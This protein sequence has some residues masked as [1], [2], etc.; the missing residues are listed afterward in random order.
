MN[1]LVGMPMRGEAA[2]IALAR[3]G[4]AIFFL[5]LIALSAPLEVR[6]VTSASLE[7]EAI[8]IVALM[9]APAT[10]SIVSR[11]VLREG[12][13]D[14]SFRLFGS[15][16]IR[17]GT[18]GI[19]FA[20]FVGVFAYITAWALG[21]A[22]FQSPIPEE[23]ALHL[24]SAPMNLAIQLVLAITLGTLAN[25]FGVIGEEVGWRGYMLTRLIEGQ[26]PMPIFLSGV[27]WSA[28]HLPLVFAG[29]YAVVGGHT[30]ASAGLFTIGTIAAGYV[31]AHVRLSSGSVWPAVVAHAAWNSI[32]QGTFDRATQGTSIA[33]GESGY[34]TCMFSIVFAV[35]LY[36]V[37]PLGGSRQSCSDGLRSGP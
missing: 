9:F 12:F 1:T 8:A 14:V 15:A 7:G 27:L 17:A 19:A 13:A 37:S 36:R 5:C 22:N 34:L 26:F 4:L 3:R 2:T 25:S 28:W 29:H 35:V 16:G 20:L 10:A 23:S 24:G 21:L 32:I 31:A 11:L 30:F 6:L 18:I 33:V